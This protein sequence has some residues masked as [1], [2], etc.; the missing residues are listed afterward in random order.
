VTLVNGGR[1]VIE[2]SFVGGAGGVEVPAI[3]AAGSDASI[4]YS[5]VLGGTNIDMPAPALFC[6]GASDITVRN[7][8][9]LA[10]NALPEIAC[11]GVT[12]DYSATETDMG[13]TNSAVGNAMSAWFANVTDDFSLLAGHPFDDV[14]QWEVGDPPTDITGVTERP[15]AQGPDVAGA[16]ILP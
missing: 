10:F 16:F 7:S 13:G 2:N 6:S 5:T 3:S 8:I 15:T 1:A 12:M 11:A 9:L 4:L 14:A